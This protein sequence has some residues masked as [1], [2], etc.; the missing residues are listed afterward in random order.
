MERYP[1]PV[2]LDETTTRM[3]SDG[4]GITFAVFLV[5]VL[6]L[7]VAALFSTAPWV[8]LATILVS[9]FCGLMMGICVFVGSMGSQGL[10]VD[11]V[12]TGIH[13]RWRIGLRGNGGIEWKV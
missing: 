3:S 8:L 2:T 5:V 1:E 12:A 7:C 11:R 13:R 4:A 6:A 9:A 10:V